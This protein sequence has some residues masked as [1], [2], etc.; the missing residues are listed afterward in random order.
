MARH[1]AR[2]L[3]LSIPMTNQVDRVEIVFQPIATTRPDGATLIRAIAIH[4]DGRIRA[5]RGADKSEAL[6]ALLEKLSA[7]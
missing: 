1:L 3:Q 6:G 5:A 7:E 4:S 2:Y